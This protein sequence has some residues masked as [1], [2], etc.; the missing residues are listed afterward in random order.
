MKTLDRNR[1][2]RTTKTEAVVEEGG[3]TDI[4]VTDGRVTDVRVTDVRV[5]DVRVTDVN[6]TDVRATDVNTGITEVLNMRVGCWRA[7]I[8][9]WTEP[10]AAWQPPYRGFTGTSYCRYCLGSTATGAF[11]RGA[12]VEGSRAAKSAVVHQKRG[13]GDESVS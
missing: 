3:G 11:H 4:G 12:R 2:R 10:T 13:T 9:V 1:L 8:Y 6:V 7:P 5:T